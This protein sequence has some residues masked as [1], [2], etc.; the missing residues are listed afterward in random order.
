LLL[1][2]SVGSAH[3]QTAEFTRSY[4]AANN[5]YRDGK[6]DDA[7]AGYETVLKHGFESGPLYYNLG[8]SYFKKQ[9]FGKALVNYERARR[10]MPRDLDLMA[11]S[12]FAAS[13][14]QNHVPFTLSPWQKLW[15]RHIE[16]YS[17]DE[18][19]LII[20]VLLIFLG[21]AHLLVLYFGWKT[22]RLA[23]GGFAVLFLIFAYGLQMKLS[24][25]R[26]AGILIK[27]AAA[28]FEPSDKATIYFELPV[29]QRVQVHER[30]G[31]WAKIERPDGKAG[32]VSEESLEG[33]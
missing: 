25:D 31:G 2:A 7:I 28:R 32:W 14:V 10:L 20:S 17:R 33:I 9:Q 13:E 29:G 27:T 19:V 26:D 6:Y 15:Q 30:E 4:A 18:M 8:N 23:M 24:A 1:A 3:A 21:A 16:F 11:N 12:Q 5:A 22:G